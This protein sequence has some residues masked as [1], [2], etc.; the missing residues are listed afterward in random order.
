MCSLSR[1][2]NGWVVYENGQ[3]S[4]GNAKNYDP[5]KETIKNLIKEGF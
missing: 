5:I 4:S 2:R 1:T 3:T